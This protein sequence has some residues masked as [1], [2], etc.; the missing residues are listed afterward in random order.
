[1]ALI[2]SRMWAICVAHW[3]T[4]YPAHNWPL[5]RLPGGECASS[6][7][8]YPEEQGQHDPGRPEL[9]LGVWLEERVWDQ[10]A[11]PRAWR[12]STARYGR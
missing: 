6:A 12:A 4:N 9:P 2:C 7:R 11:W 5:R 10:M 3:H 1:M 8:L